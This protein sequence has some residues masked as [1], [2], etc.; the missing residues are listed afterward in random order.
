MSYRIEY[1]YAIAKEEAQRF[2][3]ARDR[4]VVA[5]LG[6]DNNVY[7]TNTKRAR[8]W[9]VSFFGTEIQVLK[10]AVYFA[11]ACESG[12]L[13]PGGRSATPEAY[14]SKIRRL[15]KRAKPLEEGTWSWAA[16]IRIPT[17]HEGIRFLSSRG[18]EGCSQT[19]YGEALLTFSIPYEDRN[20]AFEFADQYP[21]LP[22]WMLARVRGLQRA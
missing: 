6:G 11:G 20:I 12:C 5:V 22:P 8:S 3:D 15:L 7:E 10:R 19:Q 18:Y 13:K 14:I 16:E 17:H 21:D 1:A 9:D 2:P 4:F